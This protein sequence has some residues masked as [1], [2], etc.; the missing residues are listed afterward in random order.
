[1]YPTKVN[2]G[3]HKFK[4][5]LSHRHKQTRPDNKYNIFYTKIQVDSSATKERYLWMPMS[6]RM[7]AM[8]E[9][10][11]VGLGGEQLD[12]ACRTLRITIQACIKNCKLI[13]RLI[14][15]KLLKSLKCLMNLQ[16]ADPRTKP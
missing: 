14:C 5:E 1:M 9:V 16:T 4:S 2:D 6:S 10:M 15:T 12:T 7:A 3:K 13:L 11:A 8:I